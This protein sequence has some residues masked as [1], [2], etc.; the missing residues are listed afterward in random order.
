MEFPL[1]SNPAVPARCC[2]SG[3]SLTQLLGFGL[4]FFFGV[5]AGF[6]MP[7]WKQDLKQFT[8]IL[9]RPRWFIWIAMGSWIGMVLWTHHYQIELFWRWQGGSPSA[10]QKRAGQATPFV[11][12]RSCGVQAAG[13]NS[14]NSLLHRLFRR[15]V[16]GPAEPF[17]TQDRKE[18]QDMNNE[19]S[20]PHV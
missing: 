16:T 14:G 15:A 6:K 1:P 2:A 18:T 8:N 10:A 12:L 4:P 20:N 11:N 17:F 5:L 7:Q 9:T 19:T 3:C 13:N